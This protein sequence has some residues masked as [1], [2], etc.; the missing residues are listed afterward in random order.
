[1]SKRHT[2]ACRRDTRMHVEESS[3]YAT[4]RKLCLH[5]SHL[6]TILYY[7]FALDKASPL[8]NLSGRAIAASDVSEN[9]SFQKEAGW[10]GTAV[11]DESHP[12][13]RM[14]RL[15]VACVS[16]KVLMP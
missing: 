3:H 6:L 10:A 13:A 11:R 16:T 5:N 4:R 2:D 8:S 15:S 9:R 12:T 7:S 14:Q 1:M